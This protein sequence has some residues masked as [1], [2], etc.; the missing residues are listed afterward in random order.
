MDRKTLAL[1][2]AIVLF[3]IG[4]FITCDWLINGNAEAFLFAGLI[5]LTLSFVPWK[6]GT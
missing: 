5:A 6:A 2:A 4:L 3:G 1:L